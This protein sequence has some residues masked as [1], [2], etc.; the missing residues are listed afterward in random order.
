MIAACQKQ[1]PRVKLVSPITVTTYIIKAHFHTL[2]MF[3][4]ILV[5]LGSQFLCLR[6]TPV[7]TLFVALNHVTRSLMWKIETNDRL[8]NC[9]CQP[10]RRFFSQ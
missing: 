5:A 9:L 10:I 2:H 7:V 1:T 8:R 3:N 4:N 6:R